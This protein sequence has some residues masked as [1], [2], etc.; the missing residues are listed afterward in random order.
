VEKYRLTNGGFKCE[1]GDCSAT[2]LPNFQFANNQKSLK[3]VCSNGRWLAQNFDGSLFNIPT[4]ERNY[5]CRIAFCFS[6]SPNKFQF[7]LFAYPH[8][9]IEEFALLQERYAFH[10]ALFLSSHIKKK[11]GKEN[12]HASLIFLFLSFSLFSVQMSR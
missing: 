10:F 7:Q 1:R 2:C 4:C 8:A 5:Y 3:V 9:K 12:F 11:K 6:K